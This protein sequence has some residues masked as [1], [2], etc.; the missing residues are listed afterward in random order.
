MVDDPLPTAL[1][2]E[3]VAKPSP[4]PA[5]PAKATPT[6]EVPKVVEEGS[7]KKKKKEK[8]EDDDLTKIREKHA[9]E[10][11]SARFDI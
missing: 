6:E 4:P 3:F 9:K 8:A 10:H 11:L 1:V 2:P 5:A 7:K